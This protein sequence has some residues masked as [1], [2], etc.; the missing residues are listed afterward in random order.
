MAPAFESFQKPYPRAPAWSEEVQLIGDPSPGSVA[1]FN[2]TLLDWEA[3]STCV[4]V[5]IG[6]NPTA[7]DLSPPVQVLSYHQAS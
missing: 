4:D 3:G 6:L 7:G 5:A 1:I 2:L